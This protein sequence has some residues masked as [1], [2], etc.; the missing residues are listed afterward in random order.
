M[1]FTLGCNYKLRVNR[2]TSI[3]ALYFPVYLLTRKLFYCDLVKRKHAN[4]L[5]RQT[6]PL[7]GLR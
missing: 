2:L 4:G 6:P 3:S 7:M 5:T 1:P